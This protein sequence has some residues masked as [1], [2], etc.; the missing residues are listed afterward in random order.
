MGKST[1]YFIAWTE[2]TNRT[3]R[4]VNAYV[5]YKRIREKSSVVRENRIFL[6]RKRKRVIDPLKEKS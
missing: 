4:N 2:I 1:L 5:E 3:L 6:S